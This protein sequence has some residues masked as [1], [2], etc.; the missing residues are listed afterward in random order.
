[1]LVDA[2]EGVGGHVG[3]VPAEPR[4]RRLRADLLDGGAPRVGEVVDRVAIGMELLGEGCE[5]V[6]LL[7]RGETLEREGREAAVRAAGLGF[8]EHPHR[9]DA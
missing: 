5:P 8:G 2:D 7:V 4:H 9:R 6:M 3:V 1:M